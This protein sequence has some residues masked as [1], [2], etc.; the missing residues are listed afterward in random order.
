MFS[1]L[2]MTDLKPVS[3]QFIYDVGELRIDIVYIN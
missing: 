2:Y 3:M 1:V